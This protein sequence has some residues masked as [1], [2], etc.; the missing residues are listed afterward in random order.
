MSFKYS[1]TTPHILKNVSFKIPKGKTTAIVG[2]SGAGKSTLANLVA[3]L[4]NPTKGTIE[5]DSINISDFTFQSW[6]SQIGVVSQSTYLFNETIEYNV[7][8]GK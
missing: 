5:A 7:K 8:F 1:E 2:A 6:H 3:R 4:Y